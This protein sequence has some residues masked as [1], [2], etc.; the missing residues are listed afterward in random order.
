MV[1]AVGAHAVTRVPAGIHTAAAQS[2]RLIRP[3]GFKLAAS[4]VQPVN[5]PDANVIHPNLAVHRKACRHDHRLLRHVTIDV[6]RKRKGVELLGPEIKLHDP[7]LQ[8]H[9]LPYASVIVYFDI[10]ST[11]REHTFE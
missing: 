7:A 3:E 2:Q 10:M 1:C 9:A 5:A 4:K 8:H 6:G 11:L